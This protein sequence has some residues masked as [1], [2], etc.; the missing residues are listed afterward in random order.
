MKTAEELASE[1]AKMIEFWKPIATAAH[2]HLTLPDANGNPV[3]LQ[4]LFD[5]PSELMASLV[6]GGWVVPKR[7]KRSMFLLSIIGTDSNRGPMQT[8]LRPGDVLLI[9]DWIASG[10]KTPPSGSGV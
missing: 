10:A 3:S 2:N 7:P 4:S 9:T 5:N 8:S 6:R 1:V